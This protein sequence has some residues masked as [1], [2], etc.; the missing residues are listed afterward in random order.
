M[1]AYLLPQ[2]LVVQAL[3]RAAV[4]S[5]MGVQ[6]G[7]PILLILPTSADYALTFLGA[8]L[9]GGAVNG[10][11]VLSDWP[12]LKSS[13]LYFTTKPIAK[14]KLSH[15]YSPQLSNNLRTKFSSPLLKVKF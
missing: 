1:P 7:E 14:M 6:R 2:L 12:G 3:R 15:C 9:A 10:G 13:S 11:R 8:M 5:R 4:F